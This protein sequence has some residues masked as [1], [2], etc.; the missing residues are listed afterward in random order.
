MVHLDGFD[1]SKW[2]SDEDVVKH[3]RV[4]RKVWAEFYRTGHME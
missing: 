4:G 1:K 2:R 3:T